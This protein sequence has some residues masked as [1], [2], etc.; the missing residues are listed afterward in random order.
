MKRTDYRVKR[1]SSF[2]VKVNHPSTTTVPIDPNLPLPIDHFL[3]RRINPH[4]GGNTPFREALRKGNTLGYLPAEIRIQIYKYTLTDDSESDSDPGSTDDSDDGSTESKPGSTSSS[5]IKAYT[6]VSFSSGHPSVGPTNLML[7]CKKLYYEIEPNFITTL[8]III[9]K[10]VDMVNM[11]AWNSRQHRINYFNYIRAI[12]FTD[13][14][15]LQKVGQVHVDRWWHE[16]AK[17]YDGLP[18]KYVPPESALFRPVSTVL[19]NYLSNHLTHIEV[20]VTLEYFLSHGLDPFQRQD[21][22]SRVLSAIQTFYDFHV[23]SSLTKLKTLVVHL[24]Y[25][26]LGM[27]GMGGYCYCWSQ[28]FE[29][30]PHHP[31]RSGF[32]DVY[33]V[34]SWLQSLFT[35]QGK[36]VTVIAAQ[37]EWPPSYHGYRVAEH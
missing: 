1:N 6:H 19:L 7:T 15:V 10:D 25:A 11:A 23:L 20:V 12:Q 37:H 35:A 22:H 30:N 14:K 31:G 5:N 4:L 29:L 17:T 3:S 28:F 27:L 16:E 2:H 21:P 26:Y 18:V 13:T 9:K 8:K 24:D 33:G 32:D 36:M 34:K